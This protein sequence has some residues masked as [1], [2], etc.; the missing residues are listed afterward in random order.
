MAFIPARNAPGQK[1]V[2]DEFSAKGIRNTLKIF[3]QLARDY[4]FGDL[5]ARHCNL[6]EGVTTTW[7]KL[8][9]GNYPADVQDVLKGVITQALTH[10][11]SKGQPKPIP[12]EWKWGAPSGTL[13]VTYKHSGPKFKIE[14]GFPPPLELRLAQ[15]LANAKGKKSKRK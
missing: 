6:N 15:R 5:T 11:D 12:I 3:N 7:R 1:D 14:L 8:I 2:N 10:T 4:R 13:R 9:D